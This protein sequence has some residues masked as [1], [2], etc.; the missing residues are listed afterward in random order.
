MTTVILAEKP[1]QAR[2][3]VEAFQRST[4]KQGYYI[5]N[6]SLLPPDTVITFGFGH[7]VELAAP[8]AYDAKYKHWSLSNLP[9]FPAHYQFIVP[10]D[11]KAQFK[12][13]KEWLSKADTIVVATDS[14]REGENIAWSIMNQAKINLKQKTIKRLWINSLEKDAIRS[15]FK[16]LK[17]GWA[18]YPKYQEA[19]TRQ[20]SDW[21]IGMNG[22][23]LYTLLLRQNGVRGVYSIGRVQTP[24]LYMVY[25]RDQAIKNF[26]P[27]PYF[28][29][30]AEI[31]ANQQKFFAK[32]DPYQ[33]FKDETGLMT[34]MQAKHVQKGSQDG[35]IKDVQ[36]QGKKSASPRLF[37]LSALQTMINRRY[38]A[39]AADVLK[40]VQALY[41]AKYLSYP[42]TDS[43]YITDQEFTYLRQNLARYQK[44]VSK[45]I[46]LPQIEP[47]SRYVNGKKVQEHHAIIMTKT[48]PSQEQLAKLSKLEQQVYD[49]VLRT[50]L[51]MFADPY[52]YEETTIITQVGDAN[53]K[54][55]GKVPTKQGWQ[56]LFDDHKA[57]QQEAATLPIVHQGDQVQAN[58]QTPQKETTPPVPFTEGT[59]ITAM[60]TAGK[61]LDD[62]AAQA[63]LKDV[64]GIG[65]SATRANVLEILKKR[66]YLVTEKNKLHVSEAGITLCKAV[67]LEPLLTSPEMTAKWE[68][69]LQQIS[70]EE[71]TP[72][73]FLSQI[74]KFVAK[75][76][77]D[78][79]T[80]L[81][82]NAAI[83]QQINH[84][85]Q[86][87]KS[88]EV[89]LETPQATVLNKQKFY[90]VKPKQG[91]DFTL[92]KKWSSKTLG[93]T[94]IKALV[95]KG[96]T[97]KLK[98]FKSKKGKSFD[99]KLK[100]DG[101]KLSFDFD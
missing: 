60:K 73:N 14:D 75:L 15:G 76:I 71:R 38:H 43:Q 97:S 51:A 17:D 1:S 80:Q 69:A 81:T 20:I 62:E 92:P 67:E 88:A 94:A 46:A 58:L 59:L 49:L 82:G 78:V 95:T 48:V 33:R 91:E 31:L 57:D 36:K 96:E 21:L 45:E 24:T 22:S 40:A 89:F 61:T 65:T 11:K 18:F 70:T 56:A 30:N 26:K 23:P 64:Q 86:A 12:I 90:I 47:Q 8:E 87:Q 72:D 79:P 66:G 27:E 77:A 9:I 16:A 5:I 2:S 52:E 68:Q 98:G 93:K 100:L 4:K 7:L 42:R 54:A 44:L 85:Q 50:T 53:F 39:S 28:E 10:T 29:L 6:D 41:E 13:V 63:I 19:Q 25:Q 3:Y 83:K 37:S 84:Q 35:L 101:H 34:F 74:K 99:A 55:T 32:L